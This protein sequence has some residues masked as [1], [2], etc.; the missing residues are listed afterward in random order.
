MLSCKAAQHAVLCADDSVRKL[1]F[2]P[3]QFENPLLD[4]IFRDKAVS[5]YVASLTDTVRS[6]D[7]LCLNGGIP[8]R[9]QQKYVIRRC[10]IQSQP[11][12]LQAD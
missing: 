8:P 5:E 4:R 2:C 3:L 11:T 10:E 1:A 9:V 6:I 7:G 12:G